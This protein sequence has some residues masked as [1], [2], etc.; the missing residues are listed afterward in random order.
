MRK[1]AVKLLMCTIA[2]LPLSAVSS[3][4]ADECSMSFAVDPIK[5][6]VAI[7]LGAGVGE[8]IV[9]TMSCVSAELLRERMFISGEAI[10]LEGLG[11]IETLKTAIKDVK[12]KIEASRQALIDTKDKAK[13]QVILKSLSAVVAAAGVVVGTA[14]CVAGGAPACLGAFGS[15]LALY[16]A[17]DGAAT[18]ASDLA[19]RATAAASELSRLSDA[20]DVLNSQVSDEQLQQYQLRY[21]QLYV[22]L[23]KS[24]REQCM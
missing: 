16:T 14:G 10:D 4:Y 24:I 21:N 2:M 22:S 1:T 6:V 7:D 8:P 3:S 5:Q 19:G 11:H 23:C 9:R 17:V 18:D 15:A 12:V 13:R 20:L